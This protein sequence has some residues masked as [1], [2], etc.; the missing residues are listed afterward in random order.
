MC[1]NSWSLLSLK[2]G[3]QAE[4]LP[5]PHWRML[6]ESPIYCCAPWLIF[7]LRRD[8]NKVRLFPTFYA[9]WLKLLSSFWDLCIHCW[10]IVFMHFWAHCKISPCETWLQVAKIQLHAWHQAF[11][12]FSVTVA[13]YQLLFQYW[14]KGSFRSFDQKEPLVS[15]ESL[16][17]FL[18][19]QGPWFSS[20][21]DL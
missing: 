16:A 3:V 6:F 7:L 13:L 20:S 9:E 8:F 18:T 10:K 11:S 2:F 19:I 12:S 14:Q 21:V 15:T 1:P 4:L 5:V 17:T